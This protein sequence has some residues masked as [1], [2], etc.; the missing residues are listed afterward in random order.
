MK[1]MVI[2]GGQQ[3]SGEVTIGGAKN[4]TVALIPAAILADT[5]VR[6]DSVPDILDVH[7]LMIILESMN[8]HS[9]FENGVMEI[10]PTNIIE[11][12]LPSKAIKSLRASYYFMGALLGKFKRATVSFPGGDNIGPRPIDQHIKGFKA[13]GA[14]VNEQNDSVYITTDNRELHG[15]HIFLDVVSV[16][17]TINVIL[18]AVK[19]NGQTTIENA[20]REPEIIDLVTFLNSMGARIRGA[21]T[22]VIRIDGVDSLSSNATHTIIPDRIEAG[23]YLSL[24]ASVGN[25]IQINNII[26]EHLE[27]FN[28]KLLE[29]GVDLDVGEDSIYVPESRN[30]HAIEIK[31]NTFPGFATD[32]QQ[33]IT[34]ALMKAQGSSVIV[35]TIYPKRV[36]HISQLQKMGANIRVEND[37]IIVAHTEQLHGA[38]VEA[39]EI[40]AGAALMI[41]GLMASGTTIITKAENILRG[42]DR[43]VY[44]LKQLGANIEIVSDAEEKVK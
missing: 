33:P 23:T 30:L 34:P 19:A 28:S 22:D 16:G 21:G 1:K 29:L 37:I 42:Y 15:A 8:V 3:L 26:P 20:A 24:A 11:S 14:T 4:S 38:E 44:K 36:K 12:A 9:T 6:L 35:D 39:G 43:I 7:N 27:S 40:R 32:L 5:P 10:D 2:R 41:A 31:T 25:G 17:A 13:L 18:A